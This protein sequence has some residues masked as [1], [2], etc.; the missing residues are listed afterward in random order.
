MTKVLSV[1]RWL[2]IAAGNTFGLAL[3][4]FAGWMTFKPLGYAL[5]GLVLLGVAWA[6]DTRRVSEVSGP[7]HH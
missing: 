4:V 6:V 7:G 1:L 5:A 2:V 3:I